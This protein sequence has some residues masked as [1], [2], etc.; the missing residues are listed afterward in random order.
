[1]KIIEF[2]KKKQ[3]V[4]IKTDQDCS[5]IIEIRNKSARQLRDL[6]IGEHFKIADWDFIVLQ[7]NECGTFVISNDLLAKNVDFGETRN[8]MESNVKKIIEGEILPIVEN[9]VGKDNIII[10]SVS[11]ASVDAENKNKF[12]IIQCKMRPLSFDEAKEYNILLV[13]KELDDWYWTLTPWSTEERGWLFPVV[14]VSPSGH[15]IHGYRDFDLDLGIRPV[16]ILNSN[17]LI[18]EENDDNN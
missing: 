13:N 10:H 16:C 1:M 5:Q 6:K 18:H 8:Y 4:E 12:G 17:I 15:F 7:H 11:L 2:F 9:A 14:V 3:E